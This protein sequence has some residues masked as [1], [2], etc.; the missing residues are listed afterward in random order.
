AELREVKLKALQLESQVRHT[1]FSVIY[2]GYANPVS[3]FLTYT[4]IRCKG[5]WALISFKH[6]IATAVIK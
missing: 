6:F 2:R 4:D 3:L 5:Q 1:V